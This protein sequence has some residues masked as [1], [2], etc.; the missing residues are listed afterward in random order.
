MGQ[1]SCNG[2]MGSTKHGKSGRATQSPR[3]RFQKKLEAERDVRKDKSRIRNP[4]ATVQELFH[5]V[6]Q[7][8]K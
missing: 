6:P 1:G 5:E 3:F 4:K 8:R 2:G 7:M